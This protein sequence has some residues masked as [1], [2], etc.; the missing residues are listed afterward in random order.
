VNDVKVPEPESKQR[1]L[2]VRDELLLALLPTATVV[3]TLGVIEA[4]GGQHLLPEHQ[5]PTQ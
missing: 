5:L 2:N 3:P 1:P 4:F